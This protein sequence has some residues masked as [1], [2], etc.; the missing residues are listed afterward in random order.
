SIAFPGSATRHRSRSS[1]ST[2]RT[3]PPPALVKPDLWAWR[4]QSAT[5]SLT[6]REYAFAT[7]PWRH[8]AES[9]KNQIQVSGVDCSSTVSFETRHLDAGE[10]PVADD[11]RRCAANPF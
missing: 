2:A 4:P 8:G 1:S 11:Q 7:C 5:Q 6:P 10:K 3:C 9:R